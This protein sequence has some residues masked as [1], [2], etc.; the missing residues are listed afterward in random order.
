MLFM[1]ICAILFSLLMTLI[2]TACTPSQRQLQAVQSMPTWWKDSLREVINIESEDLG[3][4]SCHYLIDIALLEKPDSCYVFFVQTP[5]PLTSFQDVDGFFPSINEFILIVPDWAFYDRVTREAF[6]NG[7]TLEPATANYYYHLK[8]MDNTVQID[9]VHII[10]EGHPEFSFR[11]SEPLPA[12]MQ[13]VY[14]TDQDAAPYHTWKGLTADEKM[15]AILANRAQA[16]GHDDCTSRDYPKLYTPRIVQKEMPRAS[17]I[18]I[19]LD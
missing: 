6:E 9:S 5:I 10:G 4:D 11:S 13:K 12:N 18:R 16:K 19:V 3:K 2:Q 7:L 14:Q 8:R 1:K 17:K 15:H